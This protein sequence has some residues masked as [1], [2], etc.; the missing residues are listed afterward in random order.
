M[1]R[2]KYRVT[3]RNGV[4]PDLANRISALHAFAIIHRQ[5]SLQNSAKESDPLQTVVEPA[6]IEEDTKDS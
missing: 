1:N 5:R 3:V 4:P 2:K 6:V